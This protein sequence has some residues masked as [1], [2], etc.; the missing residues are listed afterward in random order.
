MLEALWAQAFYN[1]KSSQYIRVLSQNDIAFLTIRLLTFPGLK[2]Y[3]SVL[4]WTLSTN[5]FQKNADFKGCIILRVKALDVMIII[6][7]YSECYMD[8]KTF[9]EWGRLV[10]HIYSE[11]IKVSTF[12]KVSL[13]GAIILSEIL[14]Y[15][16]LSSI[17]LNSSRQPLGSGLVAIVWPKHGL[18]SSSL[19]WHIRLHSRA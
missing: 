4:I 2:T 14:T 11:S 7:Y 10:M 15:S 12:V 5:A 17:M 13:W 3:F 18:S 1:F 6:D 19:W 9:I 8:L 16:T